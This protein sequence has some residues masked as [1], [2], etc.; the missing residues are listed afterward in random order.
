MC[1]PCLE[2]GSGGTPRRRGG[3]DGVGVE[4]NSIV[5]GSK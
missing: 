3:G 5:G 4:G 2:L 1:H